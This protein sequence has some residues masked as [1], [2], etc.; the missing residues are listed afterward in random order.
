MKKGNVGM[1]KRFSEKYG[2]KGWAFNNL[3]SE[4]YVKMPVSSWSG[5]FMYLCAV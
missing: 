2:D 3:Q 4:N 5:L 1:V